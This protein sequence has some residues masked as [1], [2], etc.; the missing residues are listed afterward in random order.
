MDI[1]QQLKGVVG[2]ELGKLYLTKVRG[3]EI[4]AEE[5]T[6][7]GLESRQA[8]LDA[9][10]R[11]GETYRPVEMK[12]Q[13]ADL[14]SFGVAFNHVVTNLAEGAQVSARPSENQEVLLTRPILLLWWPPARSVVND[15]ATMDMYRRAQVEAV[16]FGAALADLGQVLG[17]PDAARR[18]IATAIGQLTTTFLETHPLVL[19]GT[20]AR[21]WD[22]FLAALYQQQ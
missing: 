14:P 10:V 7:P 13:R 20:V 19:D 2:Q 6:V 22:S 12:L 3:L 8:K 17:A 1:Y 16:Q 9:V 21:R 4:I 11:E 15:A 5:V 18:Q